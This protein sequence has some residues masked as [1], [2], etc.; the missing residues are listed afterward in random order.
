[1]RVGE[2]MHIDKDLNDLEVREAMAD[3]EKTLY[4]LVVTNL[5][6]DKN[7]VNVDLLQTIIDNE[8]DTLSEENKNLL[9]KLNA[10][11]KDKKVKTLKI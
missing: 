6:E 8:Y 10:D 5:I 1:M 11:L 2:P 9:A 4:N 3:F 7:G